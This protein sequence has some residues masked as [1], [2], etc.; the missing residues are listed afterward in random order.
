MGEQTGIS[1]A[2]SEKKKARERLN[3]AVRRGILP[4]PD[5]LP[6]ADC[7]GPARE[8]DH[9][10]GYAVE[11][12]LSVQPVCSKCH[13]RRDDPRSSAT[14]CVRGHEFTAENTYVK[15]NGT[16]N[17]RA[18]KRAVDRGRRDAAYWRAYRARR[19]A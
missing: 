10:R 13:S 1:W 16:R 4:R 7:G 12:H 6:C 18:C 11:H 5:T 14:H 8:Y 17:C 9:F 19:A 3:I 2:D 15:P